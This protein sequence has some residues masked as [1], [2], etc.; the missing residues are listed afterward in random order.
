MLTKTF[1]VLG[2][3]NLSICM[4]D[5]KL[6]ENDHFEKYKVHVFQ[7]PIHW[8]VV[9]TK[10]FHVNSI[11]LMNGLNADMREALN[12]NIFSLKLKN[13]LVKRYDQ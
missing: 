13:K 3:K 12:E 8:T 10:S 6:I 9:Y 11:S 5:T 2:Y 7:F 1:K 4:K